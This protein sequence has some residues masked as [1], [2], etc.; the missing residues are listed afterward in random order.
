MKFL[1]FIAPNNFRDETLSMVKMFFDRWNVG[2][3]ITS[4][5]TKPCIG[6]HGAS[7]AVNLNAAKVNPSDYDGIILVDGPGIDSYKL[8]EYRPLLDM[9]LQFNNKNK[10]IGAIDNSVK[11]VARA[12]IIK[13]RN[14]AAPEDEETKRAV[15]LFHGKLTDKPIEI[16]NN[17]I[18][19]KSSSGLEGP[20]QEFL[21]HVGAI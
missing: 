6:S 16:S 7:V 11:V 2:Y 3:E 9:L 8:F 19:I 4:Y 5:S 18:T 17:I 10:M 12:N 13:D 14:I 20:L 1:I 15:Q 21:G